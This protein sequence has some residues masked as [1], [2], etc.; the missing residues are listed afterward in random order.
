MLYLLAPE[1]SAVEQDPANTLLDA[2]KQEWDDILVSSIGAPALVSCQPADGDGVVFFNP[3]REELRDEVEALLAQA[4][5]DGAVLLS[6]AMDPAHRRPPGRAGEHQSFDVVDQLRRRELPADRLAVLGAAFAREALSVTMPTFVQSRLRIFLC[7]RRADGEHLTAAVD[8]A[9]SVRHEHVF[10]DLID[11]QTGERAQE[12]IDEALSGADVLVFLDTPKAGESWWVMHELA[13]ALGRGIPVVWVRLG[14][15]AEDRSELDVKPAAEPH[16]RYEEQDL[17][18]TRAGELV[19]QILG[20][21]VRLAREQGRVSRQAQRE[22]RQWAADH[23][24]LIE[25]LDM[26]QQIFQVRHPVAA[27]VR[28]YPLRPAADVVQFFGRAPAEPD[29]QALERFLI[30]HG[31]G[32]HDRECR[33]FDAAILLDPTATGHRAVGEWSVT[34]HPTRFLRSLSPPEQPQPEAPPRLLL[35]GAF[36]AGDYAREQIV[37]AIHA[38]ATTWLTLGGAIVCGGHPT[39]VPLLVE[40]ARELLGERAHGRLIVYQSEWFVAPARYEELAAQASVVL[41]AREATRDASLTL[42]RSRMVAEGQAS[43]VLAIGGRTEEGGAHTPGIDEEIA[44]ARAYG[45]PVYLLGAPG[46]QTALLAA[47]AAEE[48][49]PWS[50]LGNRL[51]TPA[52]EMLSTSEDYE[53]AARLIWNATT[54]RE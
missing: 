25:T 22:L 53:H 1:L 26:R 10:R 51:D 31:M 40:A 5:R 8:R 32:P 24:A 4:A 20:I 33:S 46:G 35:L 19:E 6:I 17:T 39:F 9:L 11:I 3:P 52:N 36:P 13:T 54:G 2:A 47:R 48:T 15:D 29:R 50:R 27:N 49:P 28:D 23:G 30:E 18:N 41:T 37:P 43:A 38:S 34:E 12:K 21:A 44:L 45:L 16:L 7:H 42:M 14:E